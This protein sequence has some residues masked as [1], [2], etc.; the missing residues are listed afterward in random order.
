MS[1]PASTTADLSP[2]S[3]APARGDGGRRRMLLVGLGLVAVLLAVSVLGRDDAAFDGPLDPRNPGPDGA[4]ALARTLEDRGT[5]VVVVRGQRALLDERVDAGTV[6]AVTGVE[7][8]GESTVR[9]LEEHAAPAAALVYAGP[10]DVLATLAGG[11]LEDLAAAPLAPATRPAGCSEPLVEDLVVR[12]RGGTGLVDEGAG[13][14]TR[15][16]GAADG[17]GAAGLVRS[18]ATWALATPASIGNRHVLEADAAALGLRLLGQ[19]DRVVWYVPDAGDTDVSDG[20][21]LGDL[22]PP[23][24]VPGL[25]L[26]AAS[27][28]ALVLVGGRR[29]GPLVREPLPVVVRAAESTHSRGRLYHRTGDR[30]HAAQVL[31]GATRD[32]LV[33]RLRLPSDAPRAQVAAV[34][35]SRTGRDPREV[36]VL[37]APP[38]PARDSQLVELGRRLQDLEDEVRRA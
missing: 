18:G 1:G 8:L 7:A 16:F 37:L 26:V 28:L 11:A 27:V 38:L 13:T 22:L 31:A 19:G 6:V 20:V 23:W 35:A 30:G 29:L 15:C 12:T 32:R 2:R 10:A 34:V 17:G 14:T 3:A 5:D 9:R 36:E 25:W 4:Q 24:L 33:E 21:R